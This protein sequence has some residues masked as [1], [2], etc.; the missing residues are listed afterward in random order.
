MTAAAEPPAGDARRAERRA[1]RRADD[2]AVAAREAI[3]P[4][5]GE[6]PVV[7]TLPPLN[8][9]AQIVGLALGAPE[10]QRH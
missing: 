9:L 8:G 4:G 2:P 6:Q 5:R 7:G 10:F 1:E 3:K